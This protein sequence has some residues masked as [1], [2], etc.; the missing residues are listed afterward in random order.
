MAKPAPA[1]S[2]LLRLET[3]EDLGYFGVGTDALKGGEMLD[4]CLPAPEAQVQQTEAAVCFGLVRIQ[5][6]TGL[7]LA[8]GFQA[9]AGNS[10]KGQAEVEVRSGVLSFTPQSGLETSGGFD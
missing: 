9:A 7:V 6:E 10:R 3:I 4:G 5:A 8:G 2:P 1:Q